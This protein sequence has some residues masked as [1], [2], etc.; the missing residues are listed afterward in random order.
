[1]ELHL[2]LHLRCSGAAFASASQMCWSCISICMYICD[3]VELHQHLHLGCGGAAFASQMWCS[4]VVLRFRE[5]R[6]KNVRLDGGWICWWWSE[7]KIIQEIAIIWTL[8]F[9][10]Q[11]TQAIQNAW[12]FETTHATNRKHNCIPDK[13]TQ[14][15]NTFRFSEGNMRAIDTKKQYGMDLISYWII[16]WKGIEIHR[17]YVRFSIVNIWK[18]VD[19]VLDLHFKNLA[20]LWILYWILHCKCIEIK[21]FFRIKCLLERCRNRRTLCWSLNFRL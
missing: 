19:F 18:S 7:R 11:R 3:V 4:K 10:K 15:V 12:V 14:A 2:H 20:N 1:M 17:F 13:R 21:M 6:G 16:N 5:G 8:E 9:S